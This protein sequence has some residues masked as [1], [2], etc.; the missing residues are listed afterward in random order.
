MDLKFSSAGS[1]VTAGN[2]SCTVFGSEVDFEFK[3]AAPVWIGA[4]G[5]ILVPYSVHSV[6]ATP[7]SF[8]IVT[9][10]SRLCQ[11]SGSAKFDAANGWLLPAAMIDPLQ[12][13]QAAG[14]GSLCISLATGISAQ[15]VGLTGADT[16]LVHPAIVAEPGLITV[17]DF[18]AS[19]VYGKQKWTL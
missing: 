14:T 19:N 5:Q 3:K 16:T 6:C 9:S 11:L 7:D 15:W 12:L 1:G 13:G 10:E 4:I 2:A 8:D 18:F 17:V